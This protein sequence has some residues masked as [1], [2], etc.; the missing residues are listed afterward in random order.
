MTDSVDDLKR[1]LHQLDDLTRSGALPAEAAA[2]ARSTL[3]ARLVAAVMA[4]PPAPAAAPPVT[5]PEASATASSTA[6]SPR[7]SRRLVAGVVV[8]VLLFAAAG[9]LWRGQPQGWEGPADAGS[10]SSADTPASA[11][12]PMG[13]AQI[14]AMVSSLAQ[15]L[16]TQPEDADG[17]LMLGRSQAVLGRFD[18]AIPA[19]RQVLRLRPADAQ[20]MADLADALAVTGRSFAGEPEKLIA[21]ALRTDPHHLKALSLA[22]TLAFERKDYATALRHWELAV[23]TGPADSSLVA[24]MRD[25]IAEARALAGGA[26]PATS[27]PATSAPSSPAAPVA[28]SGRVELAPAAAAQARPDD[29]VFIFARPAQGQRMPLAIL[30]KRVSDL[31]LEFRLD[32]SLAMDPQA[33]LSSSTAVVVGARLSKSG[34][35]MPQPGD[36]EGLSAVV[37]PG[38]S[39]LRIVIQNAVR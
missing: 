34:Q 30:K 8:F 16:K 10:A 36:W 17:W 15:R 18:Q 14:E 39:G 35:A 9:Y 20:A 6:P 38:A 32:D 27:A 7:P 19:Y 28:V 4:T 22:G 13:T 37:A 3:Q 2:S 26:A 24:Q 21:A 25:N 29:T 23:K 12:H 33:K 5:A 11:P 31:P 1:Q